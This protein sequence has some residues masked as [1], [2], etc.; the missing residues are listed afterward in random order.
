MF[1]DILDSV[2]RVLIKIYMFF[3]YKNKLEF[4]LFA[5]TWLHNVYILHTYY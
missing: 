5:I 3:F 1:I 2:D 4:Y